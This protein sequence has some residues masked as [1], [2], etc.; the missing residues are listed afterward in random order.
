MG[1][2]GGDGK[3]ASSGASS[4]RSVKKKKAAAAPVPRVAAMEEDAKYSKMTLKDLQELFLL[5]GRF[6]MPLEDIDVVRCTHLDTQTE[7]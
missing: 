2:K 5:D 1:K 6:T 3:T 4:K 7:P